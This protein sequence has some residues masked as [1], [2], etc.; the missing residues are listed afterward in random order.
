V[1]RQH[2]V[3]GVTE[4]AVPQRS[5]RDPVFSGTD[6]RRRKRGASSGDGCGVLLHETAVLAGGRA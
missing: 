4:A 1:D 6:R 3:A 5:A 2:L